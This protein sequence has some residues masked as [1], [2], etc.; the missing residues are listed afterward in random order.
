MNRIEVFFIELFAIKLWNFRFAG[1]PSYLRLIL[2]SY[3]R[4]QKA[5]FCWWISKIVPTWENQYACSCFWILYPR[6]G[7]VLYSQI[8]PL[9]S[10]VPLPFLPV[11][12]ASWTARSLWQHQNHFY[13]P[14]ELPET[15]APFDSTSTMSTSAQLF[16]PIKSEMPSSRP[17][18]PWRQE[19][20]RK[21]ARVC[22][23]RWG[24]NYVQ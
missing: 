8:T 7:F 10:T 19:R 16:L 14:F 6:C 17:I 22:H 1:M 21:E 13:P 5:V 23:W 2:L 12:R 4:G 20:C 15:H 18:L 11:I 3:F 24:R 9:F